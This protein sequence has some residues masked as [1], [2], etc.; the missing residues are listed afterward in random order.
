MKKL[1]FQKQKMK[2]GGIMIDLH[3]MTLPTCEIMVNGQK[4]KLYGKKKNKVYLRNGD[5][6]QLKLF[7]PLQERIGVQLK[8]NG[9]KVDNDLLILKPGQEITIERYIGTNRKLTFNS[10]DIDTSNMSQERYEQAVKS[11]EKNG[12]LEIVFWNE[13]QPQPAQV[14]TSVPH[15]TGQGYYN[16]PI[17]GS[18]MTTQTNPTV[19]INGNLEVNGNLDVNGNLKVRP[20]SGTSGSSGSSGTSGCSGMSGINGTSGTRGLPHFT[21]T[22]TGTASTGGYSNVC[23]N[24]GGMGNISIGTTSPNLNFTINTSSSDFNY[25]EYIAENTDKSI[26]F[27]EYLAESTQK[28]EKKLETGRIEKG[29]VSNQYFSTIKFEV[30][31]PFYKIKFKLLPFS[32]KPVKKNSMTQQP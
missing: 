3:G 21:S 26:N 22:I 31:E 32:L 19:I 13:K 16:Y 11:I 9:V 10:Y 6:F 7:N 15:Y 24:L 23:Y 14:F 12:V 4:R 29:D 30:G 18:S 17:S 5:N 1:T 20:L 25:A 28:K 27:S 2:K 8:M